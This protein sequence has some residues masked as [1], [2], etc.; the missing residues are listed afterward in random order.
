MSEVSKDNSAD[1]ACGEINR[2]ELYLMFQTDMDFR[3]NLDGLETFIRSRLGDDS[4]IYDFRAEEISFGDFDDEQFIK[5]SVELPS[6][7]MISRKVQYRTAIVFI[8][9]TLGPKRQ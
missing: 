4:L 5:L 2:V 6:M 9:E 7:H 8:I 1:Y 3:V